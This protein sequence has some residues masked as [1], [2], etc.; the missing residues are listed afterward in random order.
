MNKNSVNNCENIGI[1]ELNDKDSSLGKAVIDA[2]DCFKGMVKYI[3]HTNNNGNDEY[4]AYLEDIFKDCK[5]SFNNTIFRS[6]LFHPLEEPFKVEKLIKHPKDKDFQGYSKEG[7]FVNPCGCPNAGRMNKKG[8]KCLYTA[9]DVEISMLEIDPSIDSYVSV[10]TI[11]CKE[12]LTIVDLSKT[13]SRNN[14]RFL[15]HLSLLI[16]ERIKLG[17]SENDYIFPQY[18]ASVCQ[19]LGYDGIGYRSRFSNNRLSARYKEGINYAIFNYDKCEAT[20]S[21][22]YKVDE[23]NITKSIQQGESSEFKNKNH[24]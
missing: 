9:S 24:P 11:K 17:N 5:K 13:E 16:Q 1:T 22:I 21:R 15:M 18:I 4:N 3:N 2:Y 10:A 23:L 20:S 6:R 7:S 8:V 12:E 19:S 14:D